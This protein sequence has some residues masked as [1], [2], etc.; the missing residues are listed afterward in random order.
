ME[1][2]ETAQENNT[3]GKKVQIYWAGQHRQEQILWISKRES[4]TEQVEKGMG[5]EQVKI[6]CVD[7]PLK[8]LMSS[9]EII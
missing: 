7:N 3:E 9:E 2:G 4:Q 6:M 1:M 8:K 5:G